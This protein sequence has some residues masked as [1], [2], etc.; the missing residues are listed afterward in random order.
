M[1]VELFKIQ[2]GKIV[3][4]EICYTS[5]T[6][7]DVVE[8]FKDNDNYMKVFTFLFYMYCPHPNKNPYVNVP[9][10][11][12]EDLLIHECEI[13]FSLDEPVFE[14]A[15]VYCEKLYLTPTRRFY[16]DCKVGLEKQGTYLR[17]TKITTG[18]DGNDTTYL[19]TLKAVGAINDQFAKVEKAYE[20]ELQA[21][22]RGGGQKAYDEG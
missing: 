2:D 15:K 12:K 20:A 22:V 6:L 14:A 13:D 7:K 10:H 5:K 3:L 16:L 4:N 1:T 11:E 8:V 18:R 9:E 19:A 17:D 21:A